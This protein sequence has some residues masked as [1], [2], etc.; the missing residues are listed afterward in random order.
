[1]GL[2]AGGS[3]LDG[4]VTWTYGP[5]RG[6]PERSLVGGVDLVALNGD[7]VVIVAAEDTLMRPGGSTEPG[8]TWVHTAARELQEEAGGRLLSLH[9]FGLLTCRWHSRPDWLADHAPH[10]RFVRVA[11][12]CDVLLDGPPT[13]PPGAEQITDVLS[14][15][16]A[17]AVARLRQVGNHHHADLIEA[18]LAARNALSQEAWFDDQRRLLETFYLDAPDVW[19][20]SGKSGG[21]AQDWELGRRV[22]SR[23]IDRDGTFLDACCAN[24]LLAETVTAWC[25]EDGIKLE[26]FGLDISPAL[27]EVAR[28]RLTD[29]ADRFFEGNALFWVGPRRFDFVYT[30]LDLVPL[31]R[32][33]ELLEHLLEYLVAPEGRLIVGQYLSSRNQTV[34]QPAVGAIL[35]DLGFPVDG[36]A[37]QDR[38]ERGPTQIAWIERR[39]WAAGK[40]G[41]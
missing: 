32:R 7:D 3:W 1:M 34:G 14:L 24:G 15:P 19:G 6:E 13:S 11:A 20:G 29:W 30:L 37:E 26:P 41:D 8:E 9:P 17:E 2:E 28:Q 40:G 39:S 16:P 22:V 35:E 21:S 25:A 33:V 38:G 31:S 36:E 27:V 4:A 23:G 10:P 18:G 5:W 12:W